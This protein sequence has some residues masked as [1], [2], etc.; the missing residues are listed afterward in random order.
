M[1]ANRSCPSSTVIPALPYADIGAA[2]K[3]LCDAFG[4]SVRLL[5]GSHRAQLNVGDGAIVATERREAVSRSAL[6]V[7]VE[8]VDAHCERARAHGARI[9]Q[10]PTT[11][12]F[13][14]RQYTAEDLEGHQWCFTQSVADIDPADWGGLP[15]AL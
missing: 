4:L 6:M 15:G 14:E 7:R 1:L 3:W 11:Y 8:D 10:P 12:P 9:L 2:V 5:I 13:G